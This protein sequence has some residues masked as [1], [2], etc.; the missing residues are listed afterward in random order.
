[1]RWGKLTFGG[2]VSAM[3]AIKTFDAKKKSDPSVKYRDSDGDTQLG[4][5][6]LSLGNGDYDGGNSINGRCRFTVVEEN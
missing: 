4:A 6:Y 2:Y 1:M 5:L 3:T